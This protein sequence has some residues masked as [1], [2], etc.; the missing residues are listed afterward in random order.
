MDD[1]IARRP[2]TDKK[3]R[4]CGYHIM[5]GRNTAAI[6]NTPIIGYTEF[7]QVKQSQFFPTLRNLS[8]H[9]ALY[10]DYTGELLDVVESD[11]ALPEPFDRIIQ[12]GKGLEVNADTCKKLKS[13]G[14]KLAFDSSCFSNG[15]VSPELADIMIIEF[16]ITSLAAQSGLIRKYKNKV[17]FLAD[18]IETWSDFKVARDMG[19]TLFRGY[20][21]LWPSDSVSRKEIKALDVCLVGILSE[22]DKPEPDFRNISDIIEHDLG[23]SYKLLRLVNSAYMAPKYRIKSISHALTYLGTRELHQWISML[24]F[25]GVKSAENSEL[26]KMS[27]I[28]GKLMALVSQELQ[29]PSTGSEPFFTG[30]FSLIDVILNRDIRELL[31]GLPITE[32]VKIALRG[33]GNEL[34]SLLSFVVSYE[35]A[36][37][38][39]IEDKYPL[40]VITPQRMASLYME[41]HRW[42][43]LIDN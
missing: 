21:F 3:A 10:L 19:Y 28:R 29:L 34:Q 16:P 5:L 27:L 36:E 22:L 9:A 26:I 6:L 18:K 20:Y 2:V 39:K 42:A 14:F 32:D 17:A 30:L 24:M 4:V 40:N 8:D 38:Q 37:W 15:A 25:S 41:A 1:F 35:Q 23:L 33:E 11:T 43:H 13:R 12:F 7:G 31:I